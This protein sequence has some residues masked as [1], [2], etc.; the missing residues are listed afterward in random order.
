MANLLPVRGWREK[1]SGLAIPYYGNPHTHGLIAAWNFFE[2]AGARLHDL[3][4]TNHGILTGTNIDWNGGGVQERTAAKFSGDATADRYDLGSIAAGNP[5]MLT[6]TDFTILAKVRPRTPYGSSF[7]RIIDKSDGG[8]SANGWGFYH[9]Q[10]E[11][12]LAIGGA[13]DFSPLTSLI[14]GD[15]ENLWT[16]SGVTFRDSDNE[17]SFYTNSFDS[18]AP[19]IRRGGPMRLLGT[20]TGNEVPTTTTNAAIG[21]WNHAT[22]REWAGD[23]SWIYIWDRLLTQD[24]VNE[25]ALAPHAL[26]QP[27]INRSFYLVRNL[28]APPTLGTMQA[29]VIAGA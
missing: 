28:N 9:R 27:A 12:A 13:E 7:P 21:N 6:T 8:F 5:L 29:I 17:I 15:L 26:F 20:A 23:I 3:V 19:T 24:E 4:G 10:N 18:T 25:V 14:R 11:M 2:G 1:P 16:V 22:D